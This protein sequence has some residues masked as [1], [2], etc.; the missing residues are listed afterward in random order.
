LKIEPPLTRFAKP[1]NQVRPTYPLFLKTFTYRCIDIGKLDISSLKLKRIPANVYTTFLG[2]SPRD[3][4][5]PP[6]VAEKG[7]AVGV[8]GDVEEIVSWKA[9]SNEVEEV[10]KE[11]GGFGG[12]KVFEVG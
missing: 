6:D 4:S 12:L 5:N 3:L 8:Y 9:G 7:D 11:I 10:E 2:I 1:L